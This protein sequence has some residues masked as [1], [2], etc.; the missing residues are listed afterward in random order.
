MSKDND[1]K[2]KADK[3]KPK[4]GVSPYKSAQSPAKPALSSFAKK[5]GRQG[6][7]RA[8]YSMRATMLLGMAAERG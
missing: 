8:E 6:I 7:A 4:T 2:P 3:T 1:K 5:P